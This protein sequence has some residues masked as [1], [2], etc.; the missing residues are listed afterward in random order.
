LPARQLA[1]QIRPPA[2]AQPREVSLETMRALLER[3]YAAGIREL[4]ALLWQTLTTDQPLSPVAERPRPGPSPEPAAADRPASLSPEEIQRCLDENNGAVEQTWRALG[5]SSR[6][7]L[8]RLI[9]RH[10][11]E[12][13]RRPRRRAEP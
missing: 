11:L 3:P 2:G 7:A 4:R 8:R 10:D 1:R 9:R 5:L 12:V 13:R 6:F